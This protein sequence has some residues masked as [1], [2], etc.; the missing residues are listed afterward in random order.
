[1]RTSYRTVSRNA[2]IEIEERRSTFIG[3]CQP[4]ADEDEAIAF[5][6]GIRAEFPMPLIMC[7]PGCLAVTDNCRNIQMMANHK[8]QQVF[9]CLMYCVSPVLRMPELL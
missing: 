1:M 4:L 6:S 3:F 7:T 2:R 9:R 5:V 8:V